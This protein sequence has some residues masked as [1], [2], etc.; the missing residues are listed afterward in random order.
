MIGAFFI[1]VSIGI[2]IVGYIYMCGGPDSVIH[3]LEKRDEEVHCESKV[4][5]FVKEMFHNFLAVPL[6]ALTALAAFIVFYTLSD[7][8]DIFS[9]AFSLSI[10]V[11]FALGILKGY[12]FHLIKQMNAH[13][14]SCQSAFQCSIF[15]SSAMCF[16]FGMSMIIVQLII[17]DNI[18]FVDILL[19]V[20]I[21]MFSVFGGGIMAFIMTKVS[22]RILHH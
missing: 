21:P 7:P 9:H 8:M 22:F 16:S 6:S 5:C 20:S 19:K 11:G 15:V 3:E 4:S 10:G 12:M 17:T 1:G 13:V 18:D 14:T 2:C